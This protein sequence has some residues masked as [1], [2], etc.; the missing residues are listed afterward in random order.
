MKFCPECGVQLVSQKFCHECGANISKYLG[1]EPVNNNTQTDSFNFGSLQV[2][3]QKEYY[4]EVGFEVENGV[5]VKYTGKS[6]TVVIPRGITEI[7]DEAFKGNEALTSVVVGEDVRIIGKAAFMH[8]FHL[9]E[10]TLPDSVEEIYELAFLA[11]YNLEKI[12]IPKKIEVIRER[13]FCG[14]HSIKKINIPASLKIILYSGFDEVRPAL[15]EIESIESWLTL[16]A[17]QGSS[18]P[19]GPLYLNGKLLTEIL[20]PN[21]ITKINNFAFYGISRLEKIVIPNSVTSIGKAAFASCRDLKIVVLPNNLTI[22]ENSA[23]GGCDSL[24]EIVIPASVQKID[25]DVFGV[26]RT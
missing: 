14:C 21:S 17:Y 15:I 25:E 11:C 20:I 10:V 23:F 7:Y 8:C 22:I 1:G 4:K 12:N 16:D 5:L 19:Q 26:V 9:K 3:A 13:T 6:R 24:Q 2:D 18:K